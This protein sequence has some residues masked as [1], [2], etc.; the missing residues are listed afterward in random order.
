MLD[1]KA[2]KLSLELV[3]LINMMRSMLSK[4]V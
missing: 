4:V 2:E 1:I 3:I